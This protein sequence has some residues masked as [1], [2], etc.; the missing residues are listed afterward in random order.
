MLIGVTIVSLALGDAVS[1]RREEALM[2]K[3]EPIQRCTAVVETSNSHYSRSCSPSSISP[4]THEL[5]REFA[6]ALLG[7]K[8]SS[9]T[10][11]PFSTNPPSLECTLRPLTQV[12]LTTPV[13]TLP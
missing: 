11:P 1:R 13:N 12:S 3:R 6:Y 5:Q 8:S 10:G 7:S 4:T 9:P 2:W